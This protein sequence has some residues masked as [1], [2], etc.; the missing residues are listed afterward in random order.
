MQA[1]NSTALIV[2][3]FGISMINVLLSV[4]FKCSMFQF[5]VGTLL[6]KMSH[7]TSK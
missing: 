4:L 5:E 6:Y 3:T 1:G 2:V 7:S